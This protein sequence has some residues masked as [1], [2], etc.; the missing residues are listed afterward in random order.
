MEP[1][2]FWSRIISNFKISLK[3]IISLL[4]SIFLHIII[5]N[6]IILMEANQ[7][8]ITIR[9]K[10]SWTLTLIWY[11][12]TAQIHRPHCVFI[13]VLLR[14]QMTLINSK[15]SSSSKSKILA[16]WKDI[17]LSWSANKIVVKLGKKVPAKYVHLY[18]RNSSFLKWST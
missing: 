11:F 5:I 4:F 2:G 7:V 10:I 17:D 15:R 16:K 12:L 6:I 9:F 13:S 1:V 3:K 14:R 18:F 8:F